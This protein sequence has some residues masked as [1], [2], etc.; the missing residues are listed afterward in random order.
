MQSSMRN[1]NRSDLTDDRVPKN[2]NTSG[3]TLSK[4]RRPFPVPRDFFTKVIN[5]IGVSTSFHKIN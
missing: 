1:S 3:E 4:D 5:S 2:N